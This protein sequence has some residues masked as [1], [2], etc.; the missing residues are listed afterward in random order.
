MKL[1]VKKK[2]IIL[3]LSVILLLL[4]AFTLAY[5]TASD[6]VTNRFS[7]KSPADEKNEVRITV[8]EE[9]DPPEEKNNEAFQKSVQIKNTG[10]ADCFIRVRLEFSSSEIRDITWLSNDENKDNNDAYVK[11]SNY[12]YS[13]L[14]NGWEYRA[15]GFY[16]YTEAV[17]SNDTTES[18]I[19][20][21]KTVYPDDTLE[22]ADEYDIFVYSESVLAVGENGERLSY[23]DA[24]KEYV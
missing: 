17:S 1:K 13:V 4:V 18:L 3:I 8:K 22:D 2:Y 7:G 19:K 10:N 16:Y 9:F 5:F 11:A 21:V 24:W 20:W 12:P 6:F 23:E 14:P 15:D